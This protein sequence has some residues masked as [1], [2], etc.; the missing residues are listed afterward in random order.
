L[1]GGWHELGVGGKKATA[2]EP[3][4]PVRGVVVFL[5][6]LDGLTPAAGTVFSDQFNRHR[7]ACICPQGDGTWWLDRIWPPFDDRTTAEKWLVQ[8]VAPFA[9]SHWRLS[10][11]C[12]GLLGLGMGGQGAL[13]LAFRHPQL[14][15]AVAGLNSVLDFHDLY[16][17]G[18]SLDEM[19]DSKERCRQ[20]TAVLQV[21]PAEYPAHV[22]FSCDPANQRWLRGN[23]RLHEKL[24]ALGIVHE[25]DFAMST[26]GDGGRYAEQ[27]A[28]RAV[29]FLAR[30]MEQQ[31]R[32]LM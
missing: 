21:H 2:Y 25:V 24:S 32:R 18:T 17:E 10:S 6:D 7:L 20:D 27:M 8:E 14:F 13:R 30:G 4:A 11:G 12:I 28:E 3:P 31:S 22:F 26:C 23:D 16:H 19:Y 5:H 1:T 9:K 15:P 29:A